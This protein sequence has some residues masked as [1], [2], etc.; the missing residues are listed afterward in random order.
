[1]ATRKAL[2]LLHE[3]SWKTG[4]PLV[5]NSIIEK[6]LIVLRCKAINVSIDI[7]LSTAIVTINGEWEK[8]TGP[9]HDKDCVFILMTRG[10]SVTNATIQC[11]KEY[12]RT[13]SAMNNDTLNKLSEKVSV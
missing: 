7:H 9:D 3:S 4:C 8:P 12:I 6:K 5:L 11:G 2:Q 13:M 10:A 1:M